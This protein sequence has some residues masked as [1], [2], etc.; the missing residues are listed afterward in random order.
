MRDSDKNRTRISIWTRRLIPSIEG[1]IGIVIFTI[2]LTDSD[3][4]L[5]DPDTGWHIRTGDYILDKLEVPKLDIF[6]HTKYGQTWIA[7]EWLSDVVFAFFHKLSG[8]TGVVVLSGYLI[9]VTFVVLF[10]ALYAA[11]LNILIVTVVTVLAAL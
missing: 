7:H 8:L 2:V 11:R 9:S 6:S 5:F 3:R 1:I 4:L 10:K